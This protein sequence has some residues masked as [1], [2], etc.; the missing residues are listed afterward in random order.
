MSSE[1]SDLTANSPAPRV[2]QLPQNMISISFNLLSPPLVLFPISL[3]H[4]LHCWKC[5]LSHHLSLPHLNLSFKSCLLQQCWPEDCCFHPASMSTCWNEMA[6]L[7]VWFYFGVLPRY[8]AISMTGNKAPN[9]TVITLFLGYTEHLKWPYLCLNPNFGPRP[10]VKITVEHCS[11]IAQ[12]S[13]RRELA[14]CGIKMSLQSSFPKAQ[15][16]EQVSGSC[17]SWN[18]LWK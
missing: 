10:P 13:T 3:S 14:P 9:P 7:I 18:W 11:D 6:N 17:T 12:D 1:G 5:S 8:M 4:S 2:T 15:D 16:S